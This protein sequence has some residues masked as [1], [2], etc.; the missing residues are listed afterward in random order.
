MNGSEENQILFRE[1]EVFLLKNLLNSNILTKSIFIYGNTA[2]G[3]S[4]ITKKVLQ[5][6]K[7]VILNYKNII[8]TKN[9]SFFDMT[10]KNSVLQMF[11]ASAH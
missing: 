11:D 4:F 9:I 1:E 2:T 3:K 7:V 8:I 10:E 5:N 6:L